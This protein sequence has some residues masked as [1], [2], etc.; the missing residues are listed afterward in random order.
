MCVPVRQLRAGPQDARQQ[1]QHHQRN[2]FPPDGCKKLCLLCPLSGYCHIIGCCLGL[3]HPAMATENVSSVAG[4]I[5]TL[6][7][8]WPW[9][10]PGDQTITSRYSTTS[11]GLLHDPHF[12][13]LIGLS[14]DLCLLLIVMEAGCGASAP[15][16][17]EAPQS[18]ACGSCAGWRFLVGISVITYLELNRSAVQIPSVGHSSAH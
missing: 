12:A 13:I 10:A 18:V 2:R 5:P 1:H 9:Q 7:R 8:R 6:S 15:G 16:V 4:G 11:L 14:S 17:Q 3:P